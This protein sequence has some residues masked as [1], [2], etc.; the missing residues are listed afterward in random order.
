MTA[1][2]L[3]HGGR[4]TIDLAALAANYRALC[5]M[6]GAVQ[7]AAA[8]KGDGY[9]LGAARVAEALAGAGCATFFVAHLG[10]G[11]ALRGLA[12][13]AGCD[14]YVLNGLLPGTA[15]GYGEARVRPVLGSLAEIDDW[16]SFAA[17]AAGAAPPAAL[18]ID[19]GFNRHGLGADELARLIAEPG[20]LAGIELALVMSHLACADAPDHPMNRAQLARFAE[21]AGHFPGVPASL[22]NSGGIMLGADYRFDLV[23]AGIAL[24]GGLAVAGRANPMAAVVGLKVPIVQ[25]RHVAQGEVIGYGATYRFDRPSRVATVSI[26]YA[27]GLPRALGAASGRPGGRLFVAGLPA[28]LVGRV[29]MDL[30][31]I[32]VGQVPERHLTRG[33]PVEV[34]GPNQGVDDLAAAAGTIGY[35]ILTRLGLRHDRVYSAAA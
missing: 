8:V 4:L 1:P 16:R 9:G 7:V 15:A 20:R 12:A 28:P 24:Y 23:R 33:A 17:A 25:V 30:T 18:H 11:R 2:P 3:G 31:A 29:S 14:I 27:D 35:E 10:E 6:A 5:A 26:G 19:T 21:A 32:D 13:L 22:A 34:L